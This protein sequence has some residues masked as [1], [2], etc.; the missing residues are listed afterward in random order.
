[1]RATTNG[2]SDTYYFGT[3]GYQHADTRGPP[4][5]ANAEPHEHADHRLLADRSAGGS[6][7]G[8]SSASVLLDQHDATGDGGIERQ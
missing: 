3:A 2:H 7:D 5:H 6:G 8:E 4:Y 1:M